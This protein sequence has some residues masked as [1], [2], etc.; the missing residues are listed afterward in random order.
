[1]LFFLQ[2]RYLNFKTQC[3]NLMGQTPFSSQDNAY[4]CLYNNKKCENPEFGA[5]FGSTVTYTIDVKNIV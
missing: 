3:L 4:S 1:M 5:F 2:K